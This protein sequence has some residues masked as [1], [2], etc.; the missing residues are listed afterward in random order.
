M[1]AM[2]FA[3]P[4]ALF[5]VLSTTVYHAGAGGTRAL[6]SAIS[7]GGTLAVLTSGWVT[8]ARRLGGSR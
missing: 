5:V 4:R 6:Y 1:C 7:V 8:R 2:T 3:M